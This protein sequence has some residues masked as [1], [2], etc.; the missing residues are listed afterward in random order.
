[1]RDMTIEAAKEAQ[2]DSR[3]KKELA[4]A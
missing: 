2:E 3:L 4:R 1:M